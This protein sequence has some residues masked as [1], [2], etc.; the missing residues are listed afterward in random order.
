MLWRAQ[1][2]KRHS[3]PPACA[4]AAAAAADR[5]DYSPKTQAFSCTSVDSS[6]VLG[7]TAYSVSMS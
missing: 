7:D 5:R 2:K 4:A 3:P 1:H 6:G